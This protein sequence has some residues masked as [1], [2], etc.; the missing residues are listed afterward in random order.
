MKVTVNPISKTAAKTVP[1]T[2]NLPIGFVK[3]SCCPS[4]KTHTISNSTIAKI[5]AQKPDA[6]SPANLQEQVVTSTS[7]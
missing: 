4:S 6:L 2:L 3:I 1:D 5:E 7:K